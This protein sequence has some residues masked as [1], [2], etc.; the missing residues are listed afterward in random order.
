MGSLAVLGL[1]ASE[2]VQRWGTLSI[3]AAL[4]IHGVGMI[5]VA[6]QWAIT[7]GVAVQA[8]WAAKNRRNRAEGL[9][10]LLIVCGV[11]LRTSQCTR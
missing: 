9:K 7:R 4:H 8:A 2:A 11:S 3:H 5:V 6:L 10:A 1:V